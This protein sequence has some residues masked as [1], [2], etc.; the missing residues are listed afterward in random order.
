VP[1]PILLHETSGGVA[2]L[3]LNRPAKR[4]A[5]TRELIEMTLAAVREIRDDEEVRLLVLTGAGP[6]FCA[7]M[8]LGEMQARAGRDNASREWHQ[9]SVVYRDLLWELFTLPIPTLLV[10]QGPA[11]A[12]GLGLLLACDMVLA[13]EESYFSLPEPKRGITAAVVAPLLAYRIGPGQAGYLLLSGRTIT[14][15]DALRIG[16]C[17]EVAAS[18]QLAERERELTAAILTGSPDALSQTKR[19]LLGGPAA[20][21]SAWLEAGMQVSAAARETADAREGLA[22]FLEKREPRWY[23]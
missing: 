17:H 22:A 2:R 18:A 11:L 9:D 21:L 1:E 8:D 20:A 10:A 14:A 15:A 3:T 23:P 6:V 19:H 16:L 12:G 4:N 13:A 7:G 5:L